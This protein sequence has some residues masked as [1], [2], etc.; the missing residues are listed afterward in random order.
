M[1]SGLASVKGDEYDGLLYTAQEEFENAK[2]AH[3]AYGSSVL[4]VLDWKHKVTRHYAP[5]RPVRYRSLSTGRSCGRP[6]FGEA[7]THGRRRESTIGVPN[8]Y[9]LCK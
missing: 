9:Y 8:S 5:R 1:L 3:D 4:F 2:R 6:R 7:L